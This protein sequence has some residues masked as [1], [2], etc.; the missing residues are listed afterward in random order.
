MD[1]GVK[2][3]ERYTLICPSILK[4]SK[5]FGKSFEEMKGLLFEQDVTPG[6]INPDVYKKLKA[7]KSLEQIAKFYKCSPSLIYKTVAK[8]HLNKP[9]YG[10]S[11]KELKKKIGSGMSAVDLAKYY[12]VC[13]DKMLTFLKQNRVVASVRRAKISPKQ[14]LSL[15]NKGYSI[16]AIAKK[17]GCTNASVRY[18]L[19]KE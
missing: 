8:Q 5:R 13:Y 14:V 7:E 12:G 19:G 10:V 6:Q 4:L 2:N 17:L 3:L 16:P 9:L 18:H 15:Y 1:G 11:R